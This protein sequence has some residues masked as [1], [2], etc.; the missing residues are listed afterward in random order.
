MQE[1]K[2]RHSIRNLIEDSAKRGVP[3]R[4]MFEL[5]YRCNFKCVHCYISQED[6][7]QKT[8]DRYQKSENARE[9]SSK[10]VF[11]ILDEL[12]D[13][14]VLNIGFTGGEIFLRDDILDILIYAR[15][16]GFIVSLLTNGSLISEEMVD[17]LIKYG[18]KRF[19]MSFLGA[20]LETF[21]RITQISGSFEKVLA[22]I[23]M[24]K[25]KGASVLM[26]S[27]VMDI[28]VEEV[29]KIRELANSL[30]IRFRY[31][32]FLLP[33]LDG[34]MKPVCHRISPEE[35]INIRRRLQ[36]TS[37]K[38]PFDY[39][40]GKQTTN[41]PSATLRASKLQTTKKRRDKFFNCLAGHSM[42]FISPYGQ[43]QVCM[44][45][46]FPNYD[47]RGGNLKEGWD[48]VKSFVDNTK[49]PR[50]WQC[51]KCKLWDFCPWCPTRAYFET[52]NMWGCSEYF[53]EIA[54]L[55]RKRYLARREKEYAI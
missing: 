7:E 30:G 47:L 26:K 16:K 34:G 37:H 13:F 22:N 52:G 4:V 10:E 55:R 42:M 40:Q 44:G 19:E 2:Y 5:T 11:R 38:Q 17:K 23:K 32:H 9:V 27:C 6:R 49:A 50:D 29:V 48:A 20:T 36:D 51:K 3:R 54:R 15:R 46:P 53:K 35:F 25:D 39:A 43:L 12:A 14:G 45:F 8:E 24:L 31:S 33:A 41:N 1:I 21:D 28:N 18:I